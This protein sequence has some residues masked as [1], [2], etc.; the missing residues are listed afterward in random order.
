MKLSEAKKG[1]KVKILSIGNR[2]GTTRRMVEMGV[3][4]GSAVEVTGVA[5][6]G[7]PIDVR[8]RGYQLSLRKEEA[9]AVEVEP[10]Q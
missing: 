8:I 2:G 4:R 7:D 5:P 3:T 1:E 10:I 9:E 6:F